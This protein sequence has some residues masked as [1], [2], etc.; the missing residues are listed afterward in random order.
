M[1]RFYVKFTDDIEWCEISLMDYSGF[2]AMVKDFPETELSKSVFKLARVELG[3]IQ[4]LPPGFHMLPPPPGFSWNNG[5]L[6]G[7]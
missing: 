1:Y 7:F 5:T 3:N 2:M 6:G 4:D